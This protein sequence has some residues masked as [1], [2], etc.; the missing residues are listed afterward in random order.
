MD[1]ITGARVSMLFVITLLWECFSTTAS[2]AS[3]PPSLVIQIGHGVAVHG[4][5]FSPVTDWK[6]LG[7]PHRDGS[8]QI[9]ATGGHDL[10]VEL[11]DLVSRR[12]FR[13]F[14]L[15]GAVL[16]LAFNARG[17]LLA[18][19]GGEVVRVWNVAD[20]LPVM[21]LQ[22]ADT[23]TGPQAGIAFTDDGSVL[24]FSGS[25]RTCIWSLLDRRQLR[26]FD[27]P[28]GFIAFHQ[29]TLAVAG[30]PHIRDNESIDLSKHY[31][32]TL[33]DVQS[34]AQIAQLT[35]DTYYVRAITFSHDGAIVVWGHGRC[36][37]NENCESIR[38]WSNGGTTV[39]N[40]AVINNVMAAS[41]CRD[42]RELIAGSNEGDVTLWRTPS[43]S[44][45]FHSDVPIGGKVYADAVAC[46]AAGLLVA[47][48][49]NRGRIFLWDQVHK[50]P[51][52]TLTGLV[53]AV[54]SLGLA[55]NAELITGNRGPRF[56]GGYSESITRWD[57]DT[58][59]PPRSVGG[60]LPLATNWRTRS[61][62]AGVGKS[63]EN[64]KI[65]ILTPNGS[66]ETDLPALGA[67]IALSR[68]QRLLAVAVNDE[69]SLWQTAPLKKLFDLP[70]INQFHY[71]QLAFSP[72]GERLAAANDDGT[73]RLWSTTTPSLL[74][75]LGVRQGSEHTVW[76]A[77]FSR[78]GK[79]I[80]SG[81]NDQHVDLWD[82]ESCK[83]RE[84][85]TG[86]AGAVKSLAY[87]GHGDLLASG[88]SDG[89]ISLW[90]TG[91]HSPLTVLRGHTWEVESVA[92]FDDNN[93]LV[94]GS[95]DGSGKLWDIRS[96]A[97]IATFVH[98]LNNHD[99]AVVTPDGLFDSS[100][101]AGEALYW[102]VD[103]TN[104]LMP[105]DAWYSDFFHPGLMS[106][107]FHGFRPKPLIDIATRLRIPSLRIMEA[108]GY[109]HLE[110]V[111]GAEYLCVSEQAPSSTQ[112]VTVYTSG[113]D[114]V[115]LPDEAFERLPSNPACAKRL[116]LPSE[117]GPY[118]VE[119]RQQRV[120]P[121]LT[122]VADSNLVVYTVAITN[123]EEW[124]SY[125]GYPKLPF[126]TADADAV[127][128]YFSRQKA[129]AEGPFKDII[130]LNGLRDSGA[131]KDAIRSGLASI[132]GVAREK[133]V[134]FLFLSGH[135]FLQKDA[136][137]FY[138]IPYIPGGR[139]AFSNQID[140]REMGVSTAML[141]ESIRNLRARRVLLIIDSCHS[142]G[143][144]E[145][146]GNIA[147]IQETLL[148][149]KTKGSEAAGAE[150]SS[151]GLY[152]LAAATPLDLAQS[153]DAWQHSL[154]TSTLLDAFD[155]ADA[156]ASGS[157]TSIWNIEQ[158]VERQVPLRAATN[159]S[160]TALITGVGYDFPIVARH[161][162]K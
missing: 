25:D 136:E 147:K 15:P 99:W 29:G 81:G 20:G 142:G 32:V 110:Q 43:S 73:V 130:I 21:T 22:A 162:V 18:A 68:D 82:A 90:R 128:S 137:M 72:N 27:V 4:L 12:Q 55:G 131:T 65:G 70:R 103:D 85:L 1:V 11:W 40:R 120:P 67:R 89:T 53:T 69:L 129:S 144:L 28:G 60:T 102:R 91:S 160:Q 133:D 148:E 140:E 149:T 93:L 132:N 119:R 66:V 123:Y 2:G 24:A 118:W 151:I 156:V 87:S 83:L 152:I 113:G 139:D 3:A 153:T 125:L 112:Q 47:S 19:A 101:D 78:D 46:D 106:E 56:E 77:V 13:T 50:R 105:I 41:F 127:E 51:V 26:C 48:A 116:R 14:S 98:F 36:H 108:N 138:L 37:G 74:C 61:F 39:T 31:T 159:Y 88:S 109:V 95:S 59:R 150:S 71:E 64:A 158:Y 63:P 16:T 38:A 86:N 42:S 30:Q 94:S 80:A 117:G 141:A 146:I 114:S 57:L 52:Y 17:T 107:L 7:F 111:A 135:G 34:E 97:E 6:T 8:G 35:G 121:K 157:A 9:L 45:A 84:S 44:E 145:A 79:T 92:F 143:A 104:E 100:A 124:L 155:H 23:G 96:F 126:A 5:A 154:L 75:I 58:G 161:I 33:I 62:A 115:Q 76:A 134:V 54:E 122:S 10:R 49:D